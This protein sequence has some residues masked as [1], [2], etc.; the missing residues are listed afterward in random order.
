M[1]QIAEGDLVFSACSLEQTHCGPFAGLA[2]TGKRV[3]LTLLSLDQIR[4][5][6]VI[7][8]NSTSSGPAVLRQLA[9]PAFHSWPLHQ[10]HILEQATATLPAATLQA[11]KETVRDLLGALSRG[12]FTAATHAG[13]TPL[14]DGFVELRR[15]FP[16]LTLTPVVQ[17]AEGQLVATRATLHGTHLDALYGFPATGRSISWDF[18]CLAQVADRVVVDQQSLADWNAA[19]AQLGLLTL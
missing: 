5:G 14:V 18:F 1:Q 10:P 17:I 2:A 6:I 3:Q 15:A 19:L 12:A 9:V 4:D 7:E 13:L 8:H 11:N 16:D